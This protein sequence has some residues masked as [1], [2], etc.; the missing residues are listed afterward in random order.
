MLRALR[1]GLDALALLP[2]LIVGLKWNEA[3]MRD[4]IEPA[5]YATDVAVEQARAGIPFRAAY[6][7]AAADGGLLHGRTPERSLSA[8]L[9]PGAAA[10]L[11][12]DQLRAR[13]HAL[14]PERPETGS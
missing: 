9:S 13:L 4:A 11:R 7:A 3:R 10:D 6:Q 5:M 12:L 2:D 8:R 1:R 14:S